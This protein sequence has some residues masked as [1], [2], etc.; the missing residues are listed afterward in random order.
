MR[1]RAGDEDEDETTRTRMKIEE[2]FLVLPAPLNQ[3][4]IVHQ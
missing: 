3:A 4:F 1:R 2:D